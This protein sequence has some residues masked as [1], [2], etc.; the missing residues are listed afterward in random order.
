MRPHPARDLLAADAGAG[1]RRGVAVHR[2]RRSVGP[3]HQGDGE[4]GHGLGWRDGKVPLGDAQ[5]MVDY[6]Y[7]V[8]VAAFATK[9]E[10]VDLPGPGVLQIVPAITD[11]E[12]ATPVLRTYRWPCRRC[13]CSRRSS[14]SRPAPI[15]SSGL[16]RASSWRATR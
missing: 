2:T 14:M 16:R 15:R 6:L 5:V 4:S 1:R 9:F 10:I 3:V 12:A 13:G 8:F 7:N 11:A